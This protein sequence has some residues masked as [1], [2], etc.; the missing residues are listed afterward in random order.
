MHES[1]FVIGARVRLVRHLGDHSP[2]GS[3]NIAPGPIGTVIMINPMA[4]IDE[5]EVFAQVRLDEPVSDVEVREHCGNCVA[6]WREGS[7]MDSQ[8]SDWALI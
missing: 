7:D 1:Q 2:G 8:P 3:Y 6:I 5:G 4:S